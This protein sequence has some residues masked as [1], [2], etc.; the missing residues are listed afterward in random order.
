MPRRSSW[1]TLE[2]NYEDDFVAKATAVAAAGDGTQEYTWKEQVFNG[3][4]GDYEDLD[5]GRSG[6]PGGV[7]LVELN[8][9]VITVPALVRC[10]LRGGEG[11]DLVYEFEAA[12][13]GGGG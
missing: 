13:T 11:D 7:P 4:S 5:A 8:N 9:Q 2:E 3:S 1:Q 10:R 12:G 6:G